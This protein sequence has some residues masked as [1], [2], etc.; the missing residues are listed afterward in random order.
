[1]QT[2]QKICKNPGNIQRHEQDHTVMTPF[3]REEALHRASR[4]PEPGILSVD[5]EDVSAHEVFAV[6]E[7]GDEGGVGGEKRGVHIYFAG[8]RFGV[9]HRCWGVTMYG[10]EDSEAEVGVISLDA[11]D[12]DRGVK[13]QDWG[14]EGVNVLPASWTCLFN[15]LSWGRDAPW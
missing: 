12:R 15:L 6:A 14:W 2:N 1:M 9:L 13:C 11:A 3:A 4:L 10:Q 5:G 7:G 8:L